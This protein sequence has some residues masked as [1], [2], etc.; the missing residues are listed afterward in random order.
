M[1]SQDL[2][3]SYRDEFHIPKVSDIIKASTQEDSDGMNFFY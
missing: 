2:L 3:R 1:D